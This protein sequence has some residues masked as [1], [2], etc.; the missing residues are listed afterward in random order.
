MVECPLGDWWCPYYGNGDCSLENYEVE[1][2]AFYAGDE[3]KETKEE[4]EEIEDKYILDD[5]GNNWY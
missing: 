4:E 5:L 2:D 1:C 3:E